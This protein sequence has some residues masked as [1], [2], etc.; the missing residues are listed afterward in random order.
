MA[1][2]AMCTQ[3]RARRLTCGVREPRRTRNPPPINGRKPRRQEIAAGNADV[4]AERC[5]SNIVTNS[6]RGRDLEI[7]NK[8]KRRSFIRARSCFP[9]QGEFWP[10]E[11]IGKEVP[12]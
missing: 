9:L 10:G 6:Q 2:T 7:F 5:V 12:S 1:C 8:Q 11:H 4:R 3:R